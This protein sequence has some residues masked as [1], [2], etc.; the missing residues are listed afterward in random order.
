MTTIREFR[1]QLAKRPDQEREIRCVGEP[2]VVLGDGTPYVNIV[3]GPYSTDDPEDVA[4]PH[5]AP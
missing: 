4:E 5:A 2:P 3:P 1:E